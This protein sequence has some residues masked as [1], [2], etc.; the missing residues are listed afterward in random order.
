MIPATVFLPFGKTISAPSKSNALP[1]PDGFVSFSVLH[2]PPSQCKNLKIQRIPFRAKSKISKLRRGLEAAKS[3]ILLGQRT[4]KDKGDSL[5]C[6]TSM[7]PQSRSFQRR[8]IMCRRRRAQN[9]MFIS[10]ND[11]DRP[12]DLE[13]ARTLCMPFLESAPFRL[14]PSRL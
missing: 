1:T 7:R 5:L 11:A 14:P 13:E 6:E 9:R 4:R 8:K 12:R 10:E 2:V 3:C